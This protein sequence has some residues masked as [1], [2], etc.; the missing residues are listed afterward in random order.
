MLW[1][2]FAFSQF[3]IIW[4]GNLPEEIPWYLRRTERRLA[5][6]RR[7]RSS[8]FHFVLPFVVLLSRDVKRN[9]R[10]LAVVAVAACSSLRFVDL[11]WLVAPGVRAR[12]ARAST[13]S[14]S[15]AVVGVGGIWLV[16]L[17]LAAAGPAAAA[18]AAIRTLP[19]AADERMSAAPTADG[20]RP[21]ARDVSVAADRRRRRSACVLA[22]V[23]VAWSRCWCSSTTSPRARRS[24]SPPANPLAAADGPQAAAASR[25]C[26]RTRSRDLRDAARRARTRRSTS[27]GWVDRDAG[28][29]RIPID[30]RHGAAR[31]ARPAGRERRTRSAQPMTRRSRRRVC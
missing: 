7:S 19:E 24:S 31:R 22:L 26:R 10:A 30:A 16:G 17:R 29:V 4:S 25:A 13:G 18:A 21:R 9:A 12:R 6:G 5:V 3:L 23:V 28:V 27:Y 2:Y 1:A 8:L 20:R 15:P 11:Y 14:T